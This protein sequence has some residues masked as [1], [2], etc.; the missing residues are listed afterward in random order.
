[1]SDLYRDPLVSA[2]WYSTALNNELHVV[3]PKAAMKCISLHHYLLRYML[4]S[5]WLQPKR[6][7]QHVY[8]LVELQDLLRHSL[9]HPVSVSELSFFN[10]YLWAVLDYR[11]YFTI[12]EVLLAGAPA[13][14]LFNRRRS[15]DFAEEPNCRLHYGWNGWDAKASVS[16]AFYTLLRLRDRESCLIKSR[17]MQLCTEDVRYVIVLSACLGLAG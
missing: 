17:I 11:M 8:L 2:V 16:S 12:P 14:M 4:Q 5:A 3:L 13:M 15:W 7:S 1:V 6:C 10:W 9:R